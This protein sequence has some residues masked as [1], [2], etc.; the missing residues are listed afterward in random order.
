MP[1]LRDYLS[2]RINYLNL[3]KTEVSIQSS[4][5]KTAFWPTCLAL[6]CTADSKAW[7][8]KDSHGSKFIQTWHLLDWHEEVCFWLCISSLLWWIFLGDDYWRHAKLERLGLETTVRKWGI[9]VWCQAE[10]RNCFILPSCI[11]S[12]LWNCFFFLSE[13]NN[14]RALDDLASQASW[15]SIYISDQVCHWSKTSGSCNLQ[16]SQGLILTD[17][18]NSGFDSPDNFIDIYT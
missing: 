9:T 16:C 8:A 13:E 2:I 10:E 18:F 6:G 15:W 7:R 11:W 12:K 3:L 4:N 1:S 14:T 5:C 17:Y